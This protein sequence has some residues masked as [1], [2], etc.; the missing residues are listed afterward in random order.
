MED[1]DLG[2]TSIRIMHDV[3]PDVPSGGTKARIQEPGLITGLTTLQ[4]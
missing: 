4:P 3:A 2:D 1:P